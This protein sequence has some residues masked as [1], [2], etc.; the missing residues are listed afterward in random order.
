MQSGEPEIM[1]ILKD[2]RVV[3]GK[4][5]PYDI[6]YYPVDAVLQLKYTVPED[7]EMRSLEPDHATIVDA[8][9]KYRYPGSESTFR[10]MIQLNDS[11]GAFDKE[12]GRLIGWCLIGSSREIL[13]L[14]VLHK[15]GK[16]HGL[17]KQI[18][19]K[20]AHDR[21]V[22]GKWALGFINPENKTPQN[23][24]MSLGHPKVGDL[25]YITT[26]PTSLVSN[27]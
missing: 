1:E 3:A 18:L 20:L 22:Q 2:L 10:R 26:T 14:R 23:I 9:W 19:I 8:A 21:A 6:Y 7:I 13:S 12:S 11:M 15:E 16:Y 17:G 4:T 24:G 27:L 25:H 5:S